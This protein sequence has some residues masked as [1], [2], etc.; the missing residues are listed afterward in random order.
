MTHFS[1]ITVGG[2]DRA[3]LSVTEACA[4]TNL[5][6]SKLYELVAAGELRAV[7]VGRS[8]RIPAQAICAWIERLDSD[9]ETAR[10]GDAA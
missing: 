7:H 10:S 8:V 9:T 3:L 2:Q 5:G 6:R 4:V 1:T